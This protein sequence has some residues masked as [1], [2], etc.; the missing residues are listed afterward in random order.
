MCEPIDTRGTW[1]HSPAAERG[2]SWDRA[3][4]ALQDTA[5]E[6]RRLR[7]TNA[8]LLDALKDLLTMAEVADEWETNRKMWPQAIDAARAAI[9]KAK[10]EGD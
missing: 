6:M 7:T 3:I 5:D 4:A 10:G 8:E 1:P 2:S 9:A